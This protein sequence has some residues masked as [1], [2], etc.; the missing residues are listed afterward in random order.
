MVL[1]K[2]CSEGFSGQK[3][4]HEMRFGRRMQKLAHCSE[5]LII[6]NRKKRSRKMS[7]TKFFVALTVMVGALLVASLAFAIEGGSPGDPS[8]K[9]RLAADTTSGSAKDSGSYDRPSPGGTTPGLN[10][11]EEKPGQ[12]DRTSGSPHDRGSYERPSPVVETTAEPPGKPEPGQVDRT[13]GSPHDRGSYDRPGPVGT[14]AA[15]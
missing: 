2:E 6:T 11:S 15:E 3:P 13:S 7:G 8:Y 12:V 1:L 9:F 4:D 10:S 14:K 5:W